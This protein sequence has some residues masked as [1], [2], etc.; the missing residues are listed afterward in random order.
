MAIA[1]KNHRKKCG[2]HAMNLK[3]QTRTIVIY[4]NISLFMWKNVTNSDDFKKG[5]KHINMNENIRE[6]VKRIQQYLV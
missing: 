3:I 5:K 1:C 2:L 6:Y 4:S